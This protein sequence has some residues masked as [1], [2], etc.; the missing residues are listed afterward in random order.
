MPCDEH[1]GLAGAAA[2]PG[3]DG[4]LVAGDGGHAV[5]IH[6]PGGLRQP[7]V[8]PPGPPGDP[9]AGAADEGL[10]RD[11][12]GLAQVPCSLAG[13]GRQRDE[14]VA[15]RLEP[16]ALVDALRAGR[17][18]KAAIDIEGVKTVLALR[19]KYATPKKTFGDPMKYYDPSYYEAALK[20]IGAR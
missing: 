5:T 6:P 8:A 19:E 7:V 3:F 12:E 17:P 20:R 13:H 9:L 11:E 2:E 4:K 10:A 16:G 15:R 14:R 1:A 18:G